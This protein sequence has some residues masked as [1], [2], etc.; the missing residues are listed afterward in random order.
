MTKPKRSFR[1]PFISALLGGAIVAVFGWIAIAAGWI[2][3]EGGSTTTVAAP[4]TA[5][6]SS[7]SSEESGNAVNQIYKADGD[8]VA[9]IES[10][11]P[12]QESPSLNPFG[13]PEA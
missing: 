10:E 12:A 13:E 6:V 5:P 1:T 3:S 8:G 9:F 4:L 7:K 11:I 2:Q